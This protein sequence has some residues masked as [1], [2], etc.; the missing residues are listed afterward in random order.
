MREYEDVLAALLSS[1][2]DVVA[3][4]GA[5]ATARLAADRNADPTILGASFI[6]LLER[7]LTSADKGAAGAAAEALARL[8]ERRSDFSCLAFTETAPS[9]LNRGL[10]DGKKIGGGAVSGD[11]TGGAWDAIDEEREERKAFSSAILRSGAL[12]HLVRLLDR[13]D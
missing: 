2:D 5:R 10:A 12:P 8:A 4:A 9:N 11:D 13:E 7:L 6:S 3:A 1:G